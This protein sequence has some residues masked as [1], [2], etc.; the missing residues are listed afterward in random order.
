MKL[1]LRD[2]DAEATAAARV[3]EPQGVGSQPDAPRGYAAEEVERLV[4]EARESALH[5]G[6]E[7]G[8]AA[9]RAEAEAGQSARVAAALE[10]VQAAMSELM[11]QDAARRRELERDVVDMLTEIGERIAP[12]FLAAHSVDLAQDRIRAGLRMASGSPWLTIRVS[13]GVE[14]ALGAQLSAIGARGDAAPP[15]VV[16][17][18]ALRDGEA[19]LDWEN[20]GLD[21]SLDRACAAVLDALRAAAAKLHDDQGKVG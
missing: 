11:E 14:Q 21:Y 2:F 3:T 4:A 17:D 10:A 1:F 15:H 8:A 18:P 13:P 7:E 12:E 5:Q 9:A 16:A 19:R 6:R 20:G